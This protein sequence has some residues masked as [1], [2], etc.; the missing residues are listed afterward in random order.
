MNT[1]LDDLIEQLEQARTKLNAAL[2]KVAPR[3]EIYPT[4]KVKQVMDH[5]TGWDELV[6]V[7]L[8]DYLQGEKP[9]LKVKG[10]I[11][12]YNAESITARKEISLEQS[13]QQYDQARQKVIRILHQLP[14]EMMTRKFSAPWGGTCTV[15]SMVKI[16]ISHELEHSKQIE[17]RLTTASGQK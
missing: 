3:V 5:I 10:G 2:D 1:T 4:W 11:D 8:Q 6:Y 15:S 7:T 14:P 9:S 12:H 17:S 16:F 13:H